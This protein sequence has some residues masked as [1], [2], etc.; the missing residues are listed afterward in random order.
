[1]T[2]SNPDAGVVFGDRAVYFPGAETVVVADV[3]V[4]RDEAS[5]VS[6]PLGERADLLD[7]FDGLLGRFDP[8]TVVIAGD[9][10]HTFGRVTDRSRRTL[11]ALRDACEA[12]G[13]T[14]ELVA[15]NHDTALASA[16]DGSVREEY[17]LGSSRRREGRGDGDRDASRTVV[18][19][20]HEPPSTA[21]D[22][23]VVGHVHPTIEIEGDRR[24]CFLRGAGTYR[25]ADV[26]V[27]P[28][29]TRLAPGVAVNDA[30]DGGLASPLVSDAS[31][32][33]PT[34]YDPDRGDAVRFPPLGEFG[35]L[36]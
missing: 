24:P 12:N 30:V 8:D 15:G 23:Y 31:A 3:H 7:R 14:L 10:V 4:G 5:A 36:L 25:G 17:V 2:G 29:F 9:V 6:L 13:S 35:R 21:A 22:R 19:H 27:L 1:M 16:R 34:V 11:D 18:C 20:G 32:M 33:A 26:L 28:A